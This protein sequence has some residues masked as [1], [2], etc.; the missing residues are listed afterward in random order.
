MNGLNGKPEI[1]EEIDSITEHAKLP[2]LESVEF[3]SSLKLIDENGSETEILFF[4]RRYEEIYDANGN[5][6]GHVVSM[7]TSVPKKAE[8]VSLVLGIENLGDYDVA[9]TGGFH[10]WSGYEFKQAFGDDVKMKS[11]KES[12]SRQRTV[13]VVEPGM[14]KEKIETGVGRS[15]GYLDLR[16]TTNEGTHDLF[17]GV[18]PNL[19]PNHEGNESV[20]IDYIEFQPNGNTVAVIKNLEGVDRERNV[21][22]QVFIVKAEPN[23]PNV[24][25]KK[26]RRR[27]R[28]STLADAYSEQL[29]KLNERRDKMFDKEIWWFSWAVEGKGVTQKSMLGELRAINEA[30]IDI[31]TICLDDGYQESAGSWEVNTDKFPDLAELALEIHKT[32][33]KAAIWVAPFMVV[34]QDPIVKEHPDWLVRGGNGKPVLFPLPQMQPTG[35]V[36]PIA[37]QPYLLDISLPEVQEHLFEVFKK[38]SDLGFDVFKTDFLSMVFMRRLRD[39]TKSTPE[40]YREFFTK[41]R[42]YVRENTKEHKEIKIIGCGAPL[43]LSIGLFEGNRMQ[44]DSL[45]PELETLAKVGPLIKRLKELPGIGKVTRGLITKLNGMFYRDSV[46]VTARRSRIY[47]QPVF[48]GFFDGLHAYDDGVLLNERHK[49][50]T[51]EAIL[52]LRAT[53]AVT[54]LTIGDSIARM[55]KDQ[56]R[57]MKEYVNEFRNPDKKI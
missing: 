11:L 20:D 56:R 8:K 45:F 24:D 18:I 38:Y 14:G 23:P 31:T 6:L 13:N 30:G 26:D 44:P 41:L 51:S 25:G 2:G 40:V 22:F 12:V 7:E 43:D 53:G 17:V 29:S 33:R 36:M 52:K 27:V 39:E 1:A 32:G 16:R 47:A 9:I 19:N 34:K 4:N 48:G 54:N 57:R 28:Y 5:L 3:P 37:D 42:Q 15:Y 50:N 55:S 46:A 10:T 21:R 49:N 35:D